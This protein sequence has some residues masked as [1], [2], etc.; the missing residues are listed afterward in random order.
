MFENRVLRGIFRLK[1]D[2]IIG[3]LR[4][5]YM[6]ELHISTHRQMQLQ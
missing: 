5:L 2:K 4:K 6:G 3:D 1:R